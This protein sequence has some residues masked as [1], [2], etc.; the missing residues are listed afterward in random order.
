MR[1]G[2]AVVLTLES[3]LPRRS[4]CRLGSEVRRNRL[5]RHCQRCVLLGKCRDRW[6]SSGERYLSVDSCTDRSVF[7]LTDDDGWMR[8]SEE[9][10]GEAKGEGDIVLGMTA[11]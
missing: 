1:L 2:L 7:W 6:N 11:L 10:G 9:E 5:R 8:E 3:V 4:I